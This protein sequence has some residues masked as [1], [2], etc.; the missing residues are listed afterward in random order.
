MSFPAVG[1][2]APEFSLPSDD[3]TVITLKAH[4]GHDVVLFFYP[5]DATPG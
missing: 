2:P 3:G 5:K 1:T 4:R